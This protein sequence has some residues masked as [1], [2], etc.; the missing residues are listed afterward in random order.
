MP[1]PGQGSSSGGSRQSSSRSFG[2]RQS[3]GRR[4]GSS[5]A[6]NPRPGSSQQRF[7]GSTQRQSSRGYNQ[8]GMGP[9]DSGPFGGGPMGPGPMGPGPGVPRRRTSIFPFLMGSMYGRS[10]ANRRNQV[11]PNY[12]PYGAP[13]RSYGSAFGIV[14]LIVVIVLFFMMCGCSDSSSDAAIPESTYNREKL[15]TGNKYVSDCIIDEEGWFENIPQTEKSLKS[16]Y[17]K[18]GV[19]P[20]IVIHDYDPALRT[21]DQKDAYAQEYFETY[22]PNEDTFMYMYFAEPND[23]EV[24]YM[25][26]VVGHNATSV[27]DAQA[28]EIFLD[29][30]EQDWYSSKS[31]DEIF[32]TAFNNTADRIMTKTATSKDVWS[33][34]LIV[35]AVVA[36]AGGVIAVMMIRRKHEAERAAETERILRTPINDGRPSNP[37]TGSSTRRNDDDDDDLLNKYGG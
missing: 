24:G 21:D 5:G 35:I 12:A 17:D 4:F 18:T 11:P 28:R 6:S 27:M 8:P 1:R 14:I 34:A 30:L 37:S 29:Y 15:E 36:V 32:V 2:T 10:Q 22:A 33:K 3:T 20:M 19:Q 7:S 23:S 9:M 13:R 16:F 26:T 25:D 31:T